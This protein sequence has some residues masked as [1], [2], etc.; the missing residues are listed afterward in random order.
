MGYTFEYQIADQRS[1]SRTRREHEKKKIK[2]H[3]P[4]LN[5]SKGGE[6]PI[7]KRGK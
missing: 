3:N 7:A 1:S 5:K 2:Q 4:P 6:G